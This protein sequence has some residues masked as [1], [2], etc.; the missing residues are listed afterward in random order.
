M[1]KYNRV[2]LEECI[3]RD[4]S[5]LI[6]GNLDTINS[7]TQ[8]YFICNCGIKHNKLFSGLYKEGGAYCKN[9]ALKNS[10][11]KIKKTNLEKYGVEYTFQSSKV[12][13]K[14]KD[15]MKQKYGVNNPSLSE[16]IKA[17][18]DNTNIERRG[19]KN[20]FQDK[21][22]KEKSKITNLKKYGVEYIASSKGHI[23][24][25][26]I[27]NK[28][29]YGVEW[30][31]Q[32]K[33]IRDKRDTTI[34]EKYGVDNISQLEETKQKV[35]D[36]NNKKFGVD[37]PTQNPD[38]MEKSIKKCY[39]YKEVISPSGKVL[40]M[41]GYEPFAYKDLI[42]R[43]R[44]DE[45]IIKR[46]EVPEIWWDDEKGKKHRYYVDFYIPKDKLMIEVKSTRTYEKDN[47]KG[48]IKGIIEACGKT[49]YKLEIWGYDNKGIKI[50]L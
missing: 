19:V 7:K 43:Y 14:I 16:E 2:L 36:T 10:K 40:K 33:D 9:C 37:Y 38:I 49:E 25:R 18:R 3:K 35:K 50:V 1:N 15:T 32:N 28:Q 46:T 44:E 22:V 45:I 20:P 47:K 34:K 29:K 17:K 4:N 12:K 48:K 11:E 30:T 13:D 39:S 26:K 27:T 5:T 31:L 41:Q 8:I 24:Q 23:E 21:E 42:I 6:E